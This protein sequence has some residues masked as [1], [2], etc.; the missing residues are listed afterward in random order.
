MRADSTGFLTRIAGNSRP[1]YSGD[2]GPAVDA[3]VGNPTGIAVDAQG[4]VFFADLLCQC[5][6]KVDLQGTIHTVAGTGTAGYSGDGGPAEK[7]SLNHPMGIA[8]GLA[9]ELFIADQEN[10]AVRMVSAAGVISTIMGT[11]KPGSSGDG[12]APALA[13]LSSPRDVALDAAGNIYIADTGNSHIR[14]IASGIVN[15]FAGTG[16]QGFSGDSG[17]AT[18]ATL[19]TP[20]AV[21]IQQ[22]SGL[23]FI[24]D[25][26]NKR[27][28][29]VDTQSGIIG[30][31]AGTDYG[32][33]PYIGQNAQLTPL[34]GLSSLAVDNTGILYFAQGRDNAASVWSILPDDTFALVAGSGFQSFS[35]DGG[36]AALAQLS[37]PSCVASDAAGNIYV[38]DTFNFRIR[39]ITPAG[40]IVT[41]AGNGQPATSGD[42]GPATSAGLYPTCVSSDPFGNLFVADS[43]NFVVRRVAADGTISTVA[44]NG[45][46]GATP[47]GVAALVASINPSAVASDSSG[48]L[49]IAD[50]VFN[51]ILKVTSDGFIHNLAGGRASSNQLSYPHGIAVDASGNVYVADTGNLRVVKLA[52]DGTLSVLAGPGAPGA[53]AA[54]LRGPWGLALDGTGN[55]YFSDGPLVRKIDASGVLTT[56]AGQSQTGYSGD[57]GPASAAQFITPLGLATDPGGNLYVADA[58]AN[59]IR[60]IGTRAASPA[61][62]PAPKIGAVTSA[63][64]NL[65]GPIAPGEILVVYGDSLG[66]SQI[67]SNA[68][69]VY[70][71]YGKQLAGSSV[72][73]NGVAG[74]MIYSFSSQ[75]S[76]VVPYGVTGS[77]VQ[78]SVLYE[79]QTS[80]PVAVNLA[81]SSPAIFTIGSGTGQAAALNQDQTLNGPSNPSAIGSVIV[82]YATGEGQTSPSGIDGAAAGSSPPQPVLPVKVTIGGQ[83]APILYAGG[84]PGAIAGIIQINAV[85]PAGIQ[86]GSAVPVSL[87]VGTASSP[88]GV[89]I[90]VSAP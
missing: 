65:T 89:T 81:A 59:A 51:V 80:D 79:G 5:V 10:H 32:P 22:S 83:P 26:G 7:A 49:Y 20:T 4:D 25:A 84:L 90:A 39:K 56:I 36:P 40:T 50:N 55:I 72:L 14:R 18:S 3:Q 73:F 58:Y 62:T 1:G 17:P 23:V 37:G 71:F 86:S 78:V 48:N 33:P 38:A 74:A 61:H 24:A 88:S 31:L 2:G 42:G 53:A 67:V 66:S 70:G 44:G 64:S 13:Q 47:D 34:P 63:A 6:R 76:A 28:R 9:G 19:N 54:I 43:Q 41:I 82:L 77:S 60:M 35:G 30:T 29:V 75:V 16:T 21:A 11:G 12:G 15:T 87:Q 57:G 69:D 27:I 85:V 46:G 45:Q 52:A 8:L 68:P